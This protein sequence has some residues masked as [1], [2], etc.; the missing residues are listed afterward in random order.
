MHNNFVPNVFQVDYTA[1]FLPGKV[2]YDL[3]E[4]IAKTASFGPL[5]LFGDLLGGAGI[6]SQSVSLDGLSQS[7]NTTSSPMFSGYGARL[8]QY[9]KE[10]AAQ[11]PML[12]KYYK[13]IAM[14][15]V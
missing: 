10:I 5:N 13:G 3:V 11:M 4:V 14:Q 12:R 2:P 7:I 9:E 6:A 1:G 15:V 8:S